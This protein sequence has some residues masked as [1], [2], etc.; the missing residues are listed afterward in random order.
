MRTFT[1][2][3]EK[4]HK[5]WEIDLQ[6]TRLTVRFGRQGTA[7]QTQEKSFPTEAAALK[8]HDKLVAEKLKKGYKETTPTAKPAASSL[9]ESL[10]AAL[11]EDPDD[12]ASHMAYADYL[13]DQNDPR[14]DFIRV[15]LALEDESKPK[16]E[17]DKLKKQEEGLLKKHETEWLG[18]LALFLLAKRT[19]EWG[20]PKYEY[21]YSRGWLS[22]LSVGHYSLAFT[23][24]LAKAP[25]VRLLRE[26]VLYHNDYHE[27]ETLPEDHVPEEAEHPHLYP[28]VRS[29]FLTNV[30]SLTV[31]ER[32]SQREEDA[33][34]PDEGF[35]CNTWA[36]G[37][38]G[39]VKAMPKLEELYL[40]AQS[41]DPDQLF[42]LK[43][44]NKLRVLALYHERDRYP[45]TRL[46]KN[47]SLGNL[48]HLLIHPH[49]LEEEPY[50]R[51][52]AVKELVN[53]KHLKSLTHLQLRLSDMGDEG[54]KEIV[55]SGTLKRLK[56]LD[57]RHG[58]VSDAGAKLFA[59]CPDAKNLTLLDLTCN[60]LTAEGVAALTAAG[61]KVAAERQWAPTG[62][63]YE[64]NQYLYAGDLE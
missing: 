37:V 4:S 26:L 60:C 8:E 40:Y 55:K 48:T 59:G 41:T 23:R 31:G 45:I 43:T 6:G 5:F 50:I 24:A 34:G 42:S 3:D 22:R 49:N 27:G 47:P 46:A 64:D 57:L 51:T 11:V 7:G 54:V 15:Q 30:R 39:I 32:P 63:E 16:A 61:V 20:E 28:L 13:T 33:C 19:K 38:V 2:S 56:V 12:L 58:R 1:Y 9:R 36:E 18:D 10:E 35:S 44:L 17:R 25:Q 52:P 14:G 53:S 62:D 29:P 21:V